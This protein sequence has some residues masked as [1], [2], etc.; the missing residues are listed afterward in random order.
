MVAPTGSTSSPGPRVAS[1][2]VTRMGFGPVRFTIHD[3]LRMVEGGVL[4]EDSTV[5]LIDGEFVYRDRFDLKGD[6]IVEGVGHNFVV[7]AFDD[8]AARVN[9]SARYLRTQCTL[10][11]ADGYAPIPDVV[12]LRGGRTDYRTRLPTAG[13]AFCV[14]E[15]ADSSYERD[16]GEKLR[17]YARAGVA[18][19]VIVNLR[20]RT[21]EVYTNPDPAAGTYA[22]PEVV[23]GRQAL[24]L[25][26]GDG[27]VFV[28]TLAEVLP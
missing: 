24:S 21:A 2:S 25:R 27:E 4:P 6:R 5:E 3:A 22:A 10:V 14:V 18:Q 26:V 20:N 1:L 16:A 9:T 19:Y 28:V 11:C 7:G 15:V 12:V 17:G 13:D 8:L 23:A